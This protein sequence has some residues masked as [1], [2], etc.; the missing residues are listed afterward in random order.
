MGAVGVREITSSDWH[1]IQSVLSSLPSSG[2][3]MTNPLR[4]QT[5][6]DLIIW[7]ETYRLVAT[8][9]AARAEATD[10]ALADM[11]RQRR[12]VGRFIRDA[13]TDAE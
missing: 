4:I 7:L 9:N 5:G 1:R 11:Q 3:S 13:M 8:G 10:E 2:T 6:E 12:A